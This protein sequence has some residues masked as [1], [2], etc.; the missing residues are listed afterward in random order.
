MTFCPIDAIRNCWRNLI[1]QSPIYSA[2]RQ[3]RIPA[4]ALP[5]LIIVTTFPVIYGDRMA[6]PEPRAAKSR[7]IHKPFRLPFVS[8][9]S[10]T[11]VPFM[12]FGFTTTLPRPGR[13]IPDRLAGG[14]PLTDIVFTPNL[15]FIDCLVGFTRR[16]QLLMRTESLYHAV[17]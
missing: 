11:S 4:M 7:I 17:R 2:V 5:L 3:R 9:Q 6:E 14:T 10:L 13:D 15:G 16:H 12:F 1:N 8:I